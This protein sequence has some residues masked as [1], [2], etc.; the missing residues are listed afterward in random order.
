MSAPFHS[1]FMH[2]IEEP[3]E[4]ELACVRRQMKAENAVKVTSNYTG[5]FHSC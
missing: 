3:F 5:R 1:R 2:S 4:G